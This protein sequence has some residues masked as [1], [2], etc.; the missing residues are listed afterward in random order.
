MVPERRAGAPH[1]DSGVVMQGAS[2][3]RLRCE[4]REGPEGLSVK[5]GEKGRCAD[6]DA[7]KSRT[8]VTSVRYE[9]V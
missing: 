7:P 3:R 1:S 5:V 6:D 4:G 8:S 9:E 2:L